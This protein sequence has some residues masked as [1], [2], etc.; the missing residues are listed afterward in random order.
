MSHKTGPAAFL[1]PTSR[2]KAL[3]RAMKQGYAPLT[4]FR[5]DLAKAVAGH[6]H[7]RHK[8]PVEVHRGN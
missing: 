8:R 2:P 5:I 6:I 4:V 7:P 3:L 1:R